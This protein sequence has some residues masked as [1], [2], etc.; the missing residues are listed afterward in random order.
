MPEAPARSTDPP[1]LLARRAARGVTRRENDD[2]LLRLYARTRSPRAHDALIRRHLPLA[3]DVARR[4]AGGAEPW[5]DLMQV[6]SIALVGAIERY[7]PARGPSFASFAVPTIDGALK[8]H[9]RDRCWL[10]RPPRS[11]QELAKRA[12]DTEARLRGALR[13]APTLT[14]LSADLDADPQRVAEALRLRAAAQFE[15]MPPDDGDEHGSLVQWTRAEEE[16]YARAE[17]RA[18]LEPLLRTLSARDREI[19]WLRFVEDRTQ[20]EIGAAIGVSQMHVWRV[21]RSAIARLSLLA[22]AA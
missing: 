11:L 5:D 8:R 19:V 6:A 15:S 18:T 16:G 21:L 14:E 17:S 22:D 12:D 10:V 4:Y 1:E 9:F 2:R 20:C 3:R 13:R 7:D